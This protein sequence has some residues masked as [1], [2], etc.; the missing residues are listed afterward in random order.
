MPRKSKAEL[1]FEVHKQTIYQAAN[2][3]YSPPYEEDKLFAI[4]VLCGYPGA[5]AYRLAY[6]QSTAT[7]QSAAALASRRLREPYMQQILNRVAQSYW[8]GYIC[9]ND[10]HCSDKRRR[11]PAWNGKRK[12]KID[13]N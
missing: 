2:S 13:P 10:K 12:N 4:L 9:L 7:N 8:S 6:P 5:T 1:D 11:Y 3:Y